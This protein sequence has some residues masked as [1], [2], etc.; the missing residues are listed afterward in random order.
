MALT[1]NKADKKTT[2]EIMMHTGVVPGKVIAYNPNKEELEKIGVNYDPGEYVKDDNF[3]EGHKQ[4][5]ASFW[6]TNMEYVVTKN[7][8]QVIVPEGDI[9]VPLMINIGDEPLKSR[10]GDKTMYVNKYG[11]TIYL[12]DPDKVYD[13]FDSEGLRTAHYGEEDL[14]KFLSAYANLE[15]S[16]EHKDENCLE[17]PNE[18]FK[19][20][21]FF[22]DFINSLI[23]D[24]PTP[25]VYFLLSLKDGGEN[26]NGQRKVKE[27]IYKQ[28]YQKK[29]QGNSAISN[30]KSFI[31][32]T[33]SAEDKRETARQYRE[34]K[35]EFFTFEP[36]IF[37]INE[38]VDKVVSSTE[39]A[40]SDDMYKEADSNF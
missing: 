36:E 35:G 29:T 7:G 14:Y 2:K 17:D 31:N 32:A 38:A 5:L 34:P 37:T 11:E 25:V 28:Y 10:E 6:L 30:F 23:T 3:N 27:I 13:W 8:E 15:Y 19:D 21:S 20:D 39:E 26:D 24:K 33:R 9:K 18:L 12:S 1:K 22:K 16:K 4:Y 40:D